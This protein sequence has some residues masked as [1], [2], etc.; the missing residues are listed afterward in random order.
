MIFVSKQKRIE[1]QLADYRRQVQLCVAG[2]RR[3]FKE[4]YEKDGQINLEKFI[5]A[6]H[7]NE[8]R[9]DDIRRE[10]EV[11]MYSKA[12]FPESRG[13]ILGLLETTDR[14]PNQAEAV[15][16]MLKTHHIVIPE[17][18]RGGIWELA[19]ICHR[20]V[21]ALLEGQ[22]QLF[23][24]FTN[25]TEAVGKVDELESKADGIEAQL[26]EQVFT[27]KLEGT[28]KLLLRDLIQS[29]ASVSD[30]AENAADRIRL[31]VAKRGI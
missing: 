29:L 7:R 31:M 13:D 24:D 23:A 21:K 27:S 22:R 18:F 9:A 17:A 8:G 30:K 15:V 11:T 12:L 19:D 14:V 5:A 3:M 10:I 2:M 28:E 25:A 26:I 6:V 16:W 1:K 4:Y 20:C